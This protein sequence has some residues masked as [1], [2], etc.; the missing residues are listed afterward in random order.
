VKVRQD[1]RVHVPR[2]HAEVGQAPLERPSLLDGVDIALF[3]VPIRTEA[4]LDQGNVV[5]SPHEEAVGRERDPVPLVRRKPLLPE[6]LRHDAEH[7][8]AVQPEL[9]AANEIDLE[10]S[11]P[12]CAGS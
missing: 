9:R 1:E 8:A 7:R 5:R 2:P 12:H 6:H 10:I 4:A 11:D 3:P